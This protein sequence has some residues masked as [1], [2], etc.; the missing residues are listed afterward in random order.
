MSTG[1][2]HKVS[3]CV[4]GVEVADGY[5]KCTLP[6]EYVNVYECSGYVC[7]CYVRRAHGGFDSDRSWTSFVT[8]M[9]RTQSKQAAAAAA[10][11]NAVCQPEECGGTLVQL[12]ACVEII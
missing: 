3:A 7:V 4:R 10:P 8:H 1:E 5:G 9:H 6:H 11:R 2:F 12:F